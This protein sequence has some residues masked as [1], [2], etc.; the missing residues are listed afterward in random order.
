MEVTWTTF[1]KTDST[2]EFGPLGGRRF[3]KS[4]TGDSTLFVDSG[5]EKREMY[6]HRVILTD[7]KP[8]QSY[9]Q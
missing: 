4:N 6:I 9:G 1:N 8:A 3:E 2:V 7:L 5:A